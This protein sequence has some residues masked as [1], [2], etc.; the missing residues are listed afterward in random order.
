[1]ITGLGGGVREEEGCGISL[2]WESLGSSRFGGPGE[3]S[4]CLWDIQQEIEIGVSPAI[5]V[6]GSLRGAVQLDVGRRAGILWREE[7]LS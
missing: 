5:E 2:R 6:S 3:E 1:M 7:L 4:G